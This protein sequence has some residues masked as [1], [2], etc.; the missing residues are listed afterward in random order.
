MSYQTKTIPEFLKSNSTKIT[1]GLILAGLAIFAFILCFKSGER[2]F[3]PF[4]Q[5]IVF[6]GGYR[7]FLGQIPFK[8]FV[9][10]FGPVVFW[11]QGL[12]FKILGVNYFAYLFHAALINLLAALISALTI[13]LIYPSSKTLSYFVG[14]ITAI[15]FYP[16]F[17]TPWVEQTA[18]F[19]SVL[20]IFLISTVIA[21]RDNPS[22][23]SIIIMIFA[24]LFSFIAFISKKN[25]GIFI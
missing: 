3:F 16:P 24:G 25:V 21:S 1:D 9:I 17:G 4:D 13:R 2:G 8:D 15:W 18:F 11:L 14:F 7:V 12:F 5:S 19:F 22:T 23:K 20:A 6:D 10:P